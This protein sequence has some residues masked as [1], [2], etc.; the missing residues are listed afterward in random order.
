[1]GSITSVGVI[2]V[3]S[4]T[5]SLSG[6]TPTSYLRQKKR[7]GGPLCSVPA[8][9]TRRCYCRAILYGISLRFNTDKLSDGNLS[10]VLVHRNALEDHCAATYSLES[11][12]LSLYGKQVRGE[13]LG[14]LVAIDHNNL[15]ILSWARQ[16]KLLY[17]SFS[18]YYIDNKPID[19]SP[20]KKKLNNISSRLSISAISFS[21]SR[22]IE[23]IVCVCVRLCACACV[24]VCMCVCVRV[25]SVP[26]WRSSQIFP[27][28]DHS[29]AASSRFGRLVKV[30]GFWATIALY[31][32]GECIELS[33][34]SSILNY[35]LTGSSS[36]NTTAT[37]GFRLSWTEISL[38]SKDNCSA[39]QGFFCPRS[40]YC[41]GVDHDGQCLT[42]ANF[43]IKESLVCD[44]EPSCSEGDDADEE[45]CSRRLVVATVASLASATLVMVIVIAFVSVAC[46][47]LRRK[48]AM[49]NSITEQALMAAA[50]S[51]SCP[52]Q[53][54]WNAYQVDRSH[55]MELPPSPPPPIRTS[56]SY[57][58]LHH[59]SLE[60][61]P[62]PPPPGSPQ[63]Q[64]LSLVDFLPNKSPPASPTLQPLSTTD[65]EIVQEYNKGIQ[66]EESLLVEHSD[67]SQVRVSEPL[68]IK[69]SNYQNE[70]LTVSYNTSE[71]TSSES[72]TSSQLTANCSTSTT[73]TVQDATVLKPPEI[74]IPTA[75]SEHCHHHSLHRHPCRRHCP[76]FQNNYHQCIYSPMN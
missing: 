58:Q 64:P 33:S 27:L 69:E 36:D 19:P 25:Y 11:T 22:I 15:L 63:I 23:N 2:T 56:Y 18:H 44:G 60:L 38:R 47:G 6:S 12:M 16:C 74:T 61:E 37:A 48:V 51:N 76:P 65:N 46:R 26:T 73:S 21:H 52:H 9:Y 39:T 45:H 17:F 14:P 75:H 28:D 35:F 7:P 62:P 72:H 59:Q 54:Q 34:F 66:D 53:N 5:A 49:R 40:V 57:E 67:D 30:R 32:N 41:V 20:N 1:M 43:C 71:A 55:W 29:P 8:C 4:C 68:A 70:Q 50:S 42:T 13:P 3:L 31:Q 10:L 24:W